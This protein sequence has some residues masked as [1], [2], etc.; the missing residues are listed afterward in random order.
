MTRIKWLQFFKEFA[1]FSGDLT[2]HVNTLCGQNTEF[3]TVTAG[4]TYSYQWDFKDL[5]AVPL[6]PVDA[7]DTVPVKQFDSLRNTTPS[8]W[9]PGGAVRATRLKSNSSRYFL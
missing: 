3:L 9:C 8:T 7:A 4:G 2:K 6:C 5:T 1:V